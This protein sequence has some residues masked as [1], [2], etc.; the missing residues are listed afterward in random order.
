MFITV[1]R[2]LSINPRDSPWQMTL[3]QLE[4]QCEK[5]C[6]LAVGPL[7]YGFC[8]RT[9]VPVSMLQERERNLKVQSIKAAETRVRQLWS[10]T[11]LGSLFPQGLPFLSLKQRKVK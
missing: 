2:D 1:Q 7:W 3:Q 9:E 8:G 6:C 11:K 5:A 4:G 10:S